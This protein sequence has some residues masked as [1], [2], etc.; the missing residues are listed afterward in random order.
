[1]QQVGMVCQMRR[2]AE[3]VPIVSLHPTTLYDGIWAH[4]S[5]VAHLLFYSCSI[6]QR[7]CVRLSPAGELMDVLAPPQ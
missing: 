7:R 6:V 5:T 2:H 1:M 4:D 3:C